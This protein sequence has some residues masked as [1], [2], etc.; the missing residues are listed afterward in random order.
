M[1]IVLRLQKDDDFIEIERKGPLP[2]KDI[3]D[4]YQK[5]ASLYCAHGK[6]ERKG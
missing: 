3:A 4:E 2:V 5:G 1:K 6:S